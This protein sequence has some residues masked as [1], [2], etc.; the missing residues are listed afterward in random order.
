MNN[1]VDSY[2]INADGIIVRVDIEKIKD[3]GLLYKVNIPQIS[4]STL[5]LLNEVKNRL[6]TEVN[7]GA[8]EILDPKIIENLKVRFKKSSE[9]VFRSIIP[10]IPKETVDFLTGTLLHEMLGLDETEF[11][12]NDDSLEEIVITSSSEPVRI[13]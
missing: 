8:Q 11:L 2:N 9:S 10:S 7:V 3:V 4:R 5:V 13:Y 1:I 12:L 6:I